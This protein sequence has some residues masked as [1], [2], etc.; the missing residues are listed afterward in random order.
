VSIPER[1]CSGG[2]LNEYQKRQPDDPVGHDPCGARTAPSRIAGYADSLGAVGTE[3]IMTVRALLKLGIALELTA[4]LSGCVLSVNPVI[5]ESGATFDPRLLGI[6]EEASGSD[7]AVF[8]RT[9]ERAY[10]IEYTSDGKVSQFQARLGEL[11]EHLVLDVWPA[12]PQN[13]QPLLSAGLQIPGHLLLTLDVGPEEIHVASLGPDSLLA[14]LHSGQVRLVHER[15]KE[16]L[17]LQ[18][19]TNQ[20]RAA[21]AGYLGRPGVLSAADRWRRA[22]GDRASGPLPP[23]AVPCFE[24][25]AWREADQ[26]FHRDPHWLG[27][28]VA[29]TVN[30]GGGRILWLFGDTWIDPSGNGTRRGARMV[31]NSVAIQIG[32][33]PTTA[34]MTFYWGRDADGKP[35]ALFPNRG[36]ESLWFGN[37]VRVGN[38][39]VLFLARTLRNTGTGLGFEHVGW[40]AVMV[41]NPDDEPSA[42]Q[43]RDLETPPNPLGILV[44]FAGV[45][46]RGDY[47]Y[48]L[49]SQNPVKSHPIFAVR[50]PAEEVRRGNLCKPE[51]WAG[52]S[53]GWIPDSSNVQRWPLFENGQS[54]LS[55]HEDQ[56]TGRF[57]EVQTLG[58]GSADV[59]MRAAPAL[60]GPWSA[61]YM[62]YRPSEYYRPNVM[63]YAAKA[64]PE[65]TGGDIVLTYATNT[66][67]FVEQLSDSLIYY[68]RFVRLTRCR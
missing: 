60:T 19:T 9:A 16:Q 33:D 1:V 65:L 13:D 25:S 54:E 48:A 29:S 44:G 24:A 62:V 35:T 15:S 64:H 66:F 17:I 39:L 18:G 47:V 52:E 31:S 11:N 67:E 50:L 41:E 7:R 43:V 30:L 10:A 59:M 42:W 56:V 4:V 20:L 36:A 51:W 63:I 8:S 22:R 6:W 34:A 45:V 3:I 32:T 12:A 37:G 28:D 5:S 58:F 61:P 40:T 21:L 23:V 38:R 27:A 68:P 46:Q 53:Q 2:G 57:I 49:G 55:I 14:A 26:I